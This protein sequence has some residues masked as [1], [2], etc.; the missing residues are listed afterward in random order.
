MSIE[1]GENMPLGNNCF[2]IIILEVCN[3]FHNRN[4]KHIARIPVKNARVQIAKATVCKYT[5]QL[6][7]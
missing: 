1:G 7:H 4:K 3:V 2:M 5:E 6:D